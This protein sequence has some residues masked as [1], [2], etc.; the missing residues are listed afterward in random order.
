MPTFLRRAL[1]PFVEL[2]DD[3]SVTATL[4]FLYAYV[5]MTAY[6]IIQPLT[7]EKVISFLGAR[8]V[9]YIIL[10]Q[11]VLI[12]LLM[13]GYTRLYAALP[14]RWA[15]PIIQVGLAA[16]T[17]IFWMLFGTGRVWVSVLFYVWG[18]L[19]GLLLTSQ[20]WTL[21]NGIYDPRQAKRLLGFV[22]AGISLGGM[23]GAGLTA[24]IVERAGANAMILACSIALLLCAPIVTMV[25]AR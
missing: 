6:N 7:R 25:M 1:T 14:K 10:A 15:L 24:I 19:I 5:A 3:E 13:I 2:R 16:V 4:M 22:G 23:T 9:P 8:N 11:G 12:G 18:A 20:F 17:F 21:A